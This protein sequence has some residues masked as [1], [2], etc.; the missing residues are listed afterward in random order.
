MTEIENKIITLLKK[1]YTYSEIQEELQVSS[2]TIAAAKKVFLSMPESSNSKLSNDPFQN[3]PARNEIVSTGNSESNL[4]F[5]TI[6]K[7]KN[8]STEEDYD[9]EDEYTTKLEVEKYRLQLAHELELE[10]IQVARD[11]KEREYDLKEKELEIRRMEVTAATTK[12]EE[13]Q[14]S[15]LFRI[16]KL[17][18][19]CEDGEYSYEEADEMLSD[20]RQLLS[21]SEQFCHIHSITFQNTKSHSILLKLIS[22]LES[23]LEELDEDDS[24]NLEFDNSFNRSVSRMSF[25]SF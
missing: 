24:E 8:M 25:T 11:E 5:Q 3:F 6:K 20:T 23:F 7:T 12:V 2:K 9:D 4:V 22:I 14:R 1:G 17:V 18:E 15:F 16:K 21:E 13:E 19:S 10:R